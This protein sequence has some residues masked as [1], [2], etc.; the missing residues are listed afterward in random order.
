MFKKIFSA[1]LAISLC[2]SMSTIAF[3]AENNATTQVIYEDSNIVVMLGNPDYATNDSAN[4]M[5]TRASSYNYVWLDYAKGGYFEV[6]TSNSGTFGITLKVESSSDASFAHVS[7]ISPNGEAVKG[8]GTVFLTPSSYGGQGFRGTIVS[9]SS[10]TY[11]IN[12]NAFT[13]VG[14]R[15]MCWLY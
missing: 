2:L 3:A 9:G 14:M 5:S 15:I 4:E 12:Y 6:Y 1:L 11:K 10:G 8:V 7:V 13:D